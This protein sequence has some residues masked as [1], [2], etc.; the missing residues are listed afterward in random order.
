MK[1]NKKIVREAFRAAEFDPSKVSD[2][3]FAQDVD[4]TD[5][6]EQQAMVLIREA[7]AFRLTNQ[8]SLYAKHIEKAMQMLVLGKINEPVPAK[9]EVK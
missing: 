5:F 4:S 3:T 9:P 2:L 6:F 7:K 1:L 8:P